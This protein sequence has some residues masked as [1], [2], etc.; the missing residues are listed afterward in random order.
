MK[1][2]NQNR[3]LRKIAYF[4][5]S[6]IKIW[7]QYLSQLLMFYK[8]HRGSWQSFFPKLFLFFVIINISCYW[9]GM[10]TVHPHHAFGSERTHYFLVQIPVGILGALFDSLSFFVTIYIARRALKTS[11]TISY[12]GHLSI[13]LVIA[14][15]A[16][17][18]VLWVFS[19]SGWLVSLVQQQP[20]SLIQRSYVYE[21]RFVDALQNPTKTDNL[22][23]IYFGAIMGISAMLPS[24]THLSLYIYSVIRYFRKKRSI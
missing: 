19:V 2:K 15:L 23:N 11:S 8:Q 22:K 5:N 20:E 9:W 21:Q 6:V 24:F 1:L 16:T 14:I 4:H 3:R 7:K 17:G 10:L 18:W 13:D 12:L